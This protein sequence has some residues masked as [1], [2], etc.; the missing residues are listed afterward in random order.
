MIGEKEALD[1]MEFMTTRHYTWIYKTILKDKAE[2]EAL[3]TQYNL[4]F[5]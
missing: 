4:L 1:H 3:F 5:E 2:L